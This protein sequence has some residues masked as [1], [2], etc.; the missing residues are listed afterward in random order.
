MEIC[1]NAGEVKY[2]RLCT[3]DNDPLNY[4]LVEFT[5]QPSVIEALKMNGTLLGS[6]NIK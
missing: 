6:K 5:E 2:C 1:S 3:R 4:A